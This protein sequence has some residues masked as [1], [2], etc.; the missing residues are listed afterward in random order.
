MI[1]EI[2]ANNLNSA[3]HAWQGGAHRIE[4]VNNLSEGGTTPTAGTLQQCLTQI[5]ID[6]YPIIRARGGDFLY[7]QSEVNSMLYDIAQFRD[8]GCKGIVIGALTAD[9][10][11]DISIN[12]AMIAQAGDMQITFHRAFDRTKNAAAS[13]QQ[14]IDLGCHR[15]L[16]SGQ[17]ANAFDGRFALKQLITDAKKDIIIMPGAGVQA[18]NV[19][20]ILA[21][22]N[23]L[24]I[25]TSMKHDCISNMQYFSTH[26]KTETYIATSQTLVQEFVAAAHA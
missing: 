24:E 11:I 14:L 17:F 9:A 10:A 21:I 3:I 8:M 19:Q 20:E 4:L 1:V 22:T 18:A 12:K 13:M 2:A 5:P 23:A 26:F 6:C 15:I 16:T 25:H 7:N